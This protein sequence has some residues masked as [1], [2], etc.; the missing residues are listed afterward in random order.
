MSDLKPMNE[1]DI[2]RVRSAIECAG[3]FGLSG[4]AVSLIRKGNDAVEIENALD[5]AEAAPWTDE[6]VDRSMVHISDIAARE[7]IK[8]LQEERNR[9]R[10]DAERWRK[11]KSMGML[12]VTNESFLSMI[13]ILIEE[14]EKTKGEIKEENEKSSPNQAQ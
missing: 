1:E 12:K 9:D 8:G 11:V 7:T 3:Y 14:S 5:E 13:D 6:E 2:G 10:A 4:H